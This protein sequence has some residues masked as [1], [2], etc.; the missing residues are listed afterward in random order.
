MTSGDFKLFEVGNDRMV[1]RN[2][3]CG[4]F[5]SD[6]ILNPRKSTELKFGRVKNTSCYSTSYDKQAY[7]EETLFHGVIP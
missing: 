2:A 1:S 6:V 7:S 4:F 5:S 3:G